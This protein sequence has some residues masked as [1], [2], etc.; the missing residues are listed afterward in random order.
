LLSW[1]CKRGREAGNPTRE[2]WKGAF[3]EVMAS[4]Q[5]SGSSG[6]PE[7][8]QW[9]PRQI[10]GVRTEDDQ[11]DRAPTWV[12]WILARA[13]RED[14]RGDGVR[15]RTETLEPQRTP[16]KGAARELDE[17][18]HVRRSQDQGRWRNAAGSLRRGSHGW[19]EMHG[20]A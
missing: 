6:G 16:L 5:H 10:R 18:R 7:S 1:I 15:F 13:P 9:R 4:T 19:R 12:C 14:L 20:S 8:P 17:C 2:A 3:S 11:G